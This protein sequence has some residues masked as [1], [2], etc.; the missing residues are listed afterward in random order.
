MMHTPGPWTVGPHRSIL[1]HAFDHSAKEI[2]TSVRGG[3]AA[4]A[5]A[6]V[7]LIAA[8]PELLACCKELRE[9][10][11]AS[12]RVLNAADLDDEFIAAMARVGVVNGIGARAE[13]AIAK[14]EGR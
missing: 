8:A 13:Q 6:N 11:A 10:L 7:Q 14:A 1:G 3:S 12:M 2:V 5:D 4:A 9:A